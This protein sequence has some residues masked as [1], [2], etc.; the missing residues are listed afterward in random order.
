[1]DVSVCACMHT[2]MTGNRGD[3][4]TGRGLQESL[5]QERAMVPVMRARTI[6]RDKG[7]QNK[8]GG[9]DSGGQ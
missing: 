6:W 4:E 7:E 8:A 1:M 2:Y 9:K 5:K 3:Y